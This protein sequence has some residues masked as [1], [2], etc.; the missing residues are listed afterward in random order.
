MFSF[1]YKEIKT[2]SWTVRIIWWK[3]MDQFHNVPGGLH[4]SSDKDKFAKISQL[5]CCV[6]FVKM[7]NDENSELFYCQYK[8]I[9]QC[10]H[11][12]MSCNWS[13]VWV[14][15]LWLL[16]C[17]SCVL[18]WTFPW[19]KSFVCNVCKWDENV[20]VSCKWVRLQAISI[21]ML[22]SIWLPISRVRLSQSRKHCTMHQIHVFTYDIKGCVREWMND[23][24]EKY[25]PFHPV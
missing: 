14:R 23:A 6:V 25:P 2:H 16:M 21:N 9:I 13:C 4:A 11:C 12:V 19:A 3:I 24:R 8:V 15:A 18:R 5:C 17:L 1:L 20:A 7:I 10:I 22:I